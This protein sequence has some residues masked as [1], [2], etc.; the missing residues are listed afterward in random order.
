MHRAFLLA[1][2]LAAAA[3][4]QLSGPPCSWAERNTV[5]PATGL[6]A[7]LHVGLLRPNPDPVSAVI[8]HTIPRQIWDS[9]VLSAFNASVRFVYNQTELSYDSGLD[10][11]RAGWFD[12]YLADVWALTRRAQGVDWSVPYDREFM[13]LV[14]LP[15]DTTR[16]QQFLSF[17][18]PLTPEL[19]ATALCTLV[20]GGVIIF[21]VEWVHPSSG[22]T[23][24]GPRMVYRYY[25]LRSLIRSLDV[26]LMTPFGSGRFVTQSSAGSV[27]VFA[28]KWLFLMV[29]ASYTANLASALTVAGAGQIPSLNDLLRQR[30]LTP[31]NAAADFARAAGGKLQIDESSLQLN[32]DTLEEA[33]ADGNP[34]RVGSLVTGQAA[35][36]AMVDS[37]QFGCRAM[38]HR[39]PFQVDTS[40][41][42]REVVP[43][44]RLRRLFDRHVLEMRQNGSL[45]DLFTNAYLP[46]SERCEASRV[47]ASSQPADPKSRQRHGDQ[48]AGILVWTACFWVG[49][50]IIA[51]VVRGFAEWKYPAARSALSWNDAKLQIGFLKKYATPPKNEYES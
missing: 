12:V 40:I 4:A 29:A 45:H 28:L 44:A 46:E 24:K 48:L 47:D 14:F 42:F 3:L 43:V 30:I 21:L 31:E 26:G 41:S 32:P 37:P 16:R 27:L 2:A 8:T 23:P 22:D 49:A 19:W 17:L 1:A 9:A 11:L 13:G 36:F 15:E 10:G 6:P 25:P 20:G 39:L 5:L 34:N 35:L 33:K 7:C 18:Q 51:G 38:Y 50:I